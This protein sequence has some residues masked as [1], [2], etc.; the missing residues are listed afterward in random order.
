MVERGCYEAISD[1]GDVKEAEI[2]AADSRNR[3]DV[4]CTGGQPKRLE[5]HTVHK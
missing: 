3:G 5:V 2:H 1:A 4:G